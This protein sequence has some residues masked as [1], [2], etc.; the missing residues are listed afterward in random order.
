MRIQNPM[1]LKKSMNLNKNNNNKIIQKQRYKK[2][3]N[4]KKK[5]KTYINNIYHIK[6]KHLHTQQRI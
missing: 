5:N 3:I 2:K 6:N 4:K 1:T